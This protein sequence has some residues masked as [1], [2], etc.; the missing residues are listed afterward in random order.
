M[1]GLISV[2]LIPLLPCTG[3]RIIGSSLDGLL[4][5]G[6]GLL[7]SLLSRISSVS[8]A[9]SSTTYHHNVLSFATVVTSPLPHLT[10]GPVFAPIW[11]PNTGVNQHITPDLVTLTD[12][13]PYLGNDHLHVGDGKGLSI[14]H[15]GHTMLCSPKRTFTSSNILHIPHITKPLL[16]VQKIYH[17]NN[18]Y[19]EFHVSM[20]CVKDL[21]TKAVLLSGQSN[22]R[23][24][25]ASRL[26]HPPLNSVLFKNVANM[27]RQGIL[28]FY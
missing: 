9:S 10:V 11:F 15:I 14:S 28:V 13:A 7:T 16:S 3:S 25:A 18:V 23:T 12:S 27:G 22:C 21:T 20:F 26:K 5:V 24:C 4:L 17:D 1:T 6:S 2:A 19:F 8:Y